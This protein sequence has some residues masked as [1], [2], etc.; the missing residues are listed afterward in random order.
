MRKATRAALSAFFVVLVLGAVVCPQQLKPTGDTSSPKQPRIDLPAAEADSRVIYR[1]APE[2]PD[3]ARRGHIEGPV[4]LRIVVDSDGAVQKMTPLRGN[5]FLLIS[6]MN[7]V[8]Q[9][10][11]KPYVVKGS[12]VEFESSITL[13]FAL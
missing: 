11:Y 8:K 6:A 10:R 2:Y 3:N 12:R 9:W 1:V 5:P 7:A 4:T 13:K